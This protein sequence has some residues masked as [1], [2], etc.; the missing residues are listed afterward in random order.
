MKINLITIQTINNHLVP[1]SSSF[2]LL[3]SINKQQELYLLKIELPILITHILKL[4]QL[5]QQ[6]LSFLYN[7]YFHSNLANLYLKIYNMELIHTNQYNEVMFQQLTLIKLLLHIILLQKHHIFE[8]RLE[9]YHHCFFL[10]FW[11]LQDYYYIQY[12]LYNINKH[13]N[14]T[15]NLLFLIECQR[16]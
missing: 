3:E 10:H 4:F 11:I 9:T 7:N 14:K 16:P 2:Y 1:F 8:L 6:N 15:T 13:L 5:I 12:L